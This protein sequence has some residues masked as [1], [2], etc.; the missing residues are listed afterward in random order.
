VRAHYIAAGWK[1]LELAGSQKAITFWY[2]A[3]AFQRKVEED[4]IA[5]IPT[6][7]KLNIT[8]P[9]ALAKSG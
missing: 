5:E 8:T 2:D 7:R 6:T 9:E 1:D 3:Q 4:A